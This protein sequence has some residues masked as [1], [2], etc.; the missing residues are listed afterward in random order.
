MGRELVPDF[1]D[2]ERLFFRVASKDIQSGRVLPAG[3][4]FPNQS[5]NRERFSFACDV[6]L[7]E[8]ANEKSRRWY[9]LGVACFLAADFPREC[10]DGANVI[11]KFTVEHA[12]VED[13]YSHSEVR[14]YKDGVLNQKG[15]KLIRKEYRADLAGKL[16]VIVAPLD[17]AETST[18]SLR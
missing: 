13:N 17:R 3:V 10:R 4:H 5:V 8:P 11:Y 1:T 6:L 14:A 7:P 2:T 15:T 9:L 16:K 18:T 12:P